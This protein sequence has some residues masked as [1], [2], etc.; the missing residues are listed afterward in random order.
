MR[1][2]RI[3]VKYCKSSSSTDRCSVDKIVCN[4]I[5]VLIGIISLE[6]MIT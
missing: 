1:G 3:V 2:K 5:R 4:H 6:S